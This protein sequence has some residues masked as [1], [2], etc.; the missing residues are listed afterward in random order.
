MQLEIF[1]DTAWVEE[2]TEE[3]LYNIL[4]VAVK[5]EGTITTDMLSNVK[6]QGIT[7]AQL[8]QFVE[9]LNNSTAFDQKGTESVNRI[10]QENI[11]KFADLIEKAEEASRNM[12]YQ[13]TDEMWIAES[14]KFKETA[15]DGGNSVCSTITLQINQ[16]MTMTRQ[17]FRGTLTVYN[18]N[19]TQAMKDV[20]LKLNVTNNKTGLV[21]TAKE[22]EMHTESLVGFKGDLPM[23][24]GWALGSDS[25]GTATI[26]FIPSKFAAPDAPVEYSFGGTLSYVD[27]YT[28]LEITREL[29]PVTLTVKPS[30]ELDLTYFLQ[31]DIFGDDALTEEVEPMVPS[32]FAVLINNKGNGDATNVRMVTQQPKII[33][34]E[35]GLLI[36]FEFLSSQLNGQEKTLAMGESIPTEFGTI[37]AHSQTYAQ[38]WL[39]STLLG[40]FV[41]YDIEATHVTSY[42]NE[43]L[44]LLDQ[45][46]IHE[47]IRGFTPM[48]EGT[49]NQR[50][51]LVN[52]LLDAED[53]PDH[54]YFT[55]ATQDVVNEIASAVIDKKS[56][57]EYHL[58]IV[59]TAA[60][61]AYG[62]LMDPTVG[63]QNLMKVVRQ[64]DGKEMNIDNVWQTDRTLR[65]GRDPIK[66]NRLHFVANMPL[67]T[68]TFILTF[69]DKPDVELAVSA[70]KGV[71]AEGQVATEPVNTVSV[72]FNKA[73]QETTFTTDDIT[74]AC[75]GIQQDASKVTITKVNDTEYQLGLQAVNGGDGYYV[76][77]IQTAGITDAEGFKGGAGRQATWVQFAGGKM[78]LTIAASPLV[79]GTVTPASGQFDYGKSVSLTA[80]AAEGYTFSKWTENDHV[81][82]EEATY[83]YTP[84]G[85]A[86][87]TAVFAPK[88]YDVTV[89]YDAQS[90]IVDGGT[91]QYAYGTEITLTATP[92]Y[93]WMFD[94]WMVDGKKKGT[95][96]TLTWTVTGT[97]AIQAVFKELPGGLL[98]GKV[99]READGA[100]IAGAIVTLRSGDVNYAGMTDSYG[101]YQI[102]VEDKSLTYDMVCQA[103]G[104]MWSP[105]VQMWFDESQQ[106]KNFSLLRGATV[107]LPSEG[108][109]TFSSPVDVILDNKAVK[110]WYLSKYDDKSFVV[111]ETTATSFA[112]GE[113]L[114]L[115]GTA[116]QRIDM[117][118]AGSAAAPGYEADAPAIA[119]IMG[120]MLI[121]TPKAPYV[122]DDDN[123]YQMKEGVNSS[124]RFSLAARGEVVPK[125]KAY[126]Q[127]TLSGQPSEVAIVWSESSLIKA[128]LYDASNPNTPH[129]DLQGRRIYKMDADVKGKKI[130]IINGRKVIVK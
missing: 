106:T 10:H 93:G 8:A 23:D 124:A 113:G 128:V 30:P 9:R 12:G 99:T 15:D 56:D 47:L 16:T 118:E 82:S 130:H 48:R 50:A 44:S 76:L 1:G 112:A 46:T 64:S 81:I 40:H 63:R 36:D 52:D 71:P 45:V 114:I 31:R 26:L 27:P 73:I 20:K 96:A 87:L 91:G 75:Q 123:V 115:S 22:F 61:W 72:V 125:G 92:A 129:Y 107:V 37:P 60:G 97:T 122:V 103:D 79:G 85:S 111:N 95:D 62:N 88:Y 21:A 58:T 55:D 14:A 34:N 66:E 101:I 3:E 78:T 116:G 105:S 49:A 18:G 4:K 120:N 24:A 100:P 28:D 67:E 38:W 43:N 126:C 2:T 25:T 7:D 102:R 119:P 117:Q 84:Q 108:A 5:Q 70:F 110:V 53:M 94:S 41:K 74:V 13:N 65:D 68:E 33:E 77:T 6:P 54:I 83:T 59:P 80:V 29:Y 109:C 127:Y 98:S 89:T 35:K 32:E 121:G 104:Y 86:N 57:T 19:K 90:G 17:A 39:Q 11:L 42:G 51:F 69:A